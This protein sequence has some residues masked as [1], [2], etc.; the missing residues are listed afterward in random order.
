MGAHGGAESTHSHSHLT[1]LSVID[2]VALV[3]VHAERVGVRA[4]ALSAIPFFYSL[5]DS[6]SALFSFGDSLEACDVAS[7]CCTATSEGTTRT[8]HWTLHPP[9]SSSRYRVSAWMR[10]LNSV[11]ASI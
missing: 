3:I 4:H 2:H 11:I 9:R 10:F 7:R 5:E 1:H 6:T 8:P